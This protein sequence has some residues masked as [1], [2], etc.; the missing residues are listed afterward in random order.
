LSAQA[1][2]VQAATIAM[3]LV[4]LVV[5]AAAAAQVTLTVCRQAIVGFPLAV[6]AL[7]SVL[8]DW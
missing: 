5:A 7:I 6:P 2:A 3:A 8:R 1:V 4:Y